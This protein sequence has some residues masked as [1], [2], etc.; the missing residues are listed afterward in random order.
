MNT[1]YNCLRLPY[2]HT[3]Q[4]GTWPVLFS[5]LNS[6]LRL[7]QEIFSCC[8]DIIVWSSHRRYFVKKAVL[9]I[10]QN[11]QE[12]T[13]AWASFVIKPRRRPAILLKKILRHRCFTVNFCEFLKK[14]FLQNTSRRLLL[15]RHQTLRKSFK[16]TGYFRASITVKCCFKALHLVSKLSNEIMLASS[17]EQF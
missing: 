3:F 17:L 12:N 4:T 10:S 8:F 13:F 7:I 14:T 16:I 9:K 1:A 2:F 5:F 11:P 6:K 15:Y